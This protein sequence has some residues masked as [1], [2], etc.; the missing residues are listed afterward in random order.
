MPAG[1]DTSAPDY[2]PPT[3]QARR[4]T[5]DPRELGIKAPTTLRPFADT[6]ATDGTLRGATVRGRSF[7]VEAKV[8]V[9]MSV[10]GISSLRAPRRGGTWRPAA[11][12]PRRPRPRRRRSPRR[13]GGPR[14]RRQRRGCRP[15]CPPPRPPRPS[16]DG[17]RCQG[18]A[19]MAA[20]IAQ[21]LS[22][23][24]RTTGS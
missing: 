15:R 1:L 23:A 7:T 6:S 3:G 13:G 16:G 12:G 14:S 22:R 2:T 17:R 11:G 24:S 10:V 4:L 9:V 8:G 19:R 21:G 20:R 18:N 5:I